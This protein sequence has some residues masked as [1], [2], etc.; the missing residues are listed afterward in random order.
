[1]SKL[2][3]GKDS[4]GRRLGRT[5][6]L[7]GFVIGRLTVIGISEL[8][9][10]KSR[11]RYWKT[12]CE[13]GT[14]KLIRQ[15]RLI[16]KKK[17]TL[18]CGC[19]QREAV[20]R[21]E[22]VENPALRKLYYSYKNSATKLRS[23]GFHLSLSEAERLFEQ[24]CHYCGVPPQRVFKETDKYFY[25]YN[26]ID[27]V[28]NTKPYEPTNVVPCCKDCNLAK[29]EMTVAQFKDWV[30]RVYSHLRLS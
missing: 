3:E 4:L 12:K 6:D 19:L 5:R 2:L 18:S 22:F 15:S 30:K 1:M 23:I 10:E 25:T 28:D 9:P 8:P 27:R 20:A 29:H 26:G 17:P 14:E 16:A 21:R 11:T 13:C 24:N 7:T